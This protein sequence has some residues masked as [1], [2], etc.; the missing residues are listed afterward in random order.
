VP[1]CPGRNRNAFLR[2]VVMFPLLRED[3]TDGAVDVPPNGG[4]V[5]P[6]RTRHR[7]KAA[8]VP[9][10]VNG[11]GLGGPVVTIPPLRQRDGGAM[12]F[13]VPHS[14][15]C[16]RRG[17]RYPSE[18][19]ASDS[20]GRLERPAVTVPA[21]DQQRGPTAAGEGAA[22][23]GAAAHGRARDAVEQ[24]GATAGGACNRLQPPPRRHSRR[25]HREPHHPHR[26]SAQPMPPHRP[27]SMA[28]SISSTSRR[29]RAPQCGTCLGGCPSA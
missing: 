10:G 7:D 15:A 25:R 16:D 23:S 13:F 28:I 21:L 8:L 27:P 5:A 19:G 24:P 1:P 12:H 20:R 2:P 3:G 29:T 14:D 17:A 11:G 18:T 26:A 4:A 9:A 22:D 6:R